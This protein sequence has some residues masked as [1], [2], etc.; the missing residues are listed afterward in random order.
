MEEYFSKDKTM[1]KILS[2][3][4]ALSVAPV[5]ASEIQFGDLSK[6][7]VENLSREFSGNFAH[8]GVSAPETNGLWGAE[9]GVI[10]GQAS[11]PDVSDIID[12]SGGEGDDFK[13][14]YHAGIQARAHLPFEIFAE[15]V[16]LPEQEIND[17]KIKNASFELGWNAG[18]FFN[19]PLDIA[20]AVNRGNSNISFTQQDP[21]SSATG[22]VELESTTTMYW[23]GVSKKF[24][25]F[26][27]YAKIGMA[28]S[29]SDLKSSFDIFDSTYTGTKRSAKNDGSYYAVGANLEFG[30]IKFGAEIS[31]VMD[32]TRA[33]GKFS[34]DF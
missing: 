1:K 18:G 28:S 20:I 22:K 12:A 19:L 33:S 13:K 27:P 29:D 34:F 7:D 14:I 26:T 17:V 6:K 21:N 2:L 32:V 15:M 10:G 16:F 23:V 11:S 8:T 30:I 5:M 9:I 24:L 4:L 3:A 31:S 25:F